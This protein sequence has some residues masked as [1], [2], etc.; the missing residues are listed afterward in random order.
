[1]SAYSPPGALPTAPARGAQY[2]GRSPA[3]QPVYDRH[4]ARD[5]LK[6]YLRGMTNAYGVVLDDASLRWAAAESVSET[7]IAAICLLETR[8]VDEIVARLTPTELEQ[9]IKIVG[10]S[11]RGYPPG[12]YDALKGERHRRSTEPP[13]QRLSPK[14]VA[15]EQAWRGGTR[16]GPEG[17]RLFE[18]FLR[19]LNGL[20]ARQTGR[21]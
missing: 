15:K 5:P 12:A 11:P 21:A 19:K 2:C 7:V 16:A 18:D 14:A 9:V 8:S 10:R 6:S 13:A 20:Q 1:M 3:W 4:D 17:R